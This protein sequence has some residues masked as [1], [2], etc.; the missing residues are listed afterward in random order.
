[1]KHLPL[2]LMVLAA[3]PLDASIYWNAGVRNATPTV[4]FAGDAAISQPARVAQIK[5]Y[6]QQYEWAANIRFQFHDACT[7]TPLANG[8]D[9]F[10][11]DIRV[12]IPGT[13]NPGVPADPY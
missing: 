13:K 2:L 12:A 8:N 3:A 9:H 1:M 10:A 4:C 11:E 7:N 6:L 5:S